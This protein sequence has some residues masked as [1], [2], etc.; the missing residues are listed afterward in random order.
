MNGGRL[1]RKEGMSGEGGGGVNGRCGGME[2]K[3]RVDRKKDKKE[4]LEGG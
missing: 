2:R 4:G 3:S 1:R